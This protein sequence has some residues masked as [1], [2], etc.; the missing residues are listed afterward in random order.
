MAMFSNRR[1]EP[2][3]PASPARPEPLPS[4]GA[5]TPARS[6]GVLSRG[7]SI[8][9]SVKFHDQLLIDCEV[10][11]DIK[12]TGTLTIG[13]HASIKG[14]ARSNSGTVQGRVEGNVLACQRCQL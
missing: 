14:Q 10:K 1:S 7:V 3:E 4:N 12:S 6:G 5:S 2:A 13:E 11:G 9:G 8:I